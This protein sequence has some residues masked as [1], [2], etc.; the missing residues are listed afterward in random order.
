LA[1]QT[2]SQ[3]VPLQVAVPFAGAG[4]G[5]HEVVPQLF[6]LLLLAQ[7]LPQGW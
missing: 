2:K 5:V 1:L 6:G 4:H 7:L 3:A